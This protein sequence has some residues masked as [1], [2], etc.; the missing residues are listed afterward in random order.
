[1]LNLVSAFFL[2]SEVGGF[3]S[4]LAVLAVLLNFFSTPVCGSL[5][6]GCRQGYPKAYRNLAN[7]KRL[8]KISRSIISLKGSLKTIDLT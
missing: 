7:L 5:R 3:S 2:G 6:Q 1:M 4:F 8:G